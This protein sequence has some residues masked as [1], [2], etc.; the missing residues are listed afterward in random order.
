[1]KTKALFTLIILFHFSLTA[2]VKNVWKDGHLTFETKNKV[3]SQGDE[4]ERD[5]D[6]ENEQLGIN[7]E[8]VDYFN[9]SEEFLSDIKKGCRQICKD[10]N[11]N[12][13]KDGKPFMSGYKSYFIVCKDNEYVI[14]AVILR[15][16]Q[17]KVY[18]ISL[19][20]YEISIQQGINILKSFKF[21]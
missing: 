8:I 2:Q 4:S 18:E 14:T 17:K 3:D 12:F 10:M 13:I 19:Y 20:C 7:M 6:A 1:M 11:M 5:Y 16:D 21:F 9:E 15:E